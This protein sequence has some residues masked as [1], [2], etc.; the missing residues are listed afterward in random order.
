MNVLEMAVTGSWGVQTLGQG[1]R[2]ENQENRDE[3]VADTWHYRR[4][5]AP[6][7]PGL[8]PFPSYQVSRLSLRFYKVLRNEPRVP[9]LGAERDI[10]NVL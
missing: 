4:Q 10:R 9:M 3:W 8:L 1:V 2:K 5:S 6:C 7:N